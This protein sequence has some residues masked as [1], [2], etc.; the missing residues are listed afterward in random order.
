MGRRPKLPPKD[1]KIIRSL[2]LEKA[3]ELIFPKGSLDYTVTTPEGYVIKAICDEFTPPKDWRCWKPQK[4]GS[5]KSRDLDARIEEIISNK[6]IYDRLR[7]NKEPCPFYATRWEIAL[8]ANNARQ[9]T[10]ERAEVERISR[11]Y[12]KK[13]SK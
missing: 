5:K 10:I 8:A 6:R 9:W 13:L 11:N 1:T 3:A 7:E 12:E 2:T 4:T